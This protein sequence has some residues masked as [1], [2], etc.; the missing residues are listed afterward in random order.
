M[1]KYVF[2]AITI[3]LV[4]MVLFFNPIIRPILRKIKEIKR[5]KREKQNVEYLRRIAEKQEKKKD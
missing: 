3:F 2:M 5:E 1:E 4:F